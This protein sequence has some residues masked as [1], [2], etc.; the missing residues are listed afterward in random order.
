MCPSSSFRKASHLRLT[1]GR[2]LLP[3]KE[4][5]TFHLQQAC[6]PEKVDTPW[7]RRWRAMLLGKRWTWRHPVEPAGT[8]FV[9][10]SSTHSAAQCCAVQRRLCRMCRSP[11]SRMSARAGAR[12]SLP[13]GRPASGAA[14]ASAVESLSAAALTCRSACVAVRVRS[15]LSTRLAG[16]AIAALLRK[17][18]R[19]RE[20]LLEVYRFRLVSAAR[21]VALRP[22]Q[23]VAHDAS[24]AH[25]RTLA[26]GV[27]AP[28]G[29]GTPI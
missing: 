2:S 12:F 23:V 9:T 27:A 7:G 13:T 16:A 26:P 8:R 6:C 19:K 11:C 14:C 5:S 25:I 3:L 29:T 18:R 20:L 21:A 24:S 15:C 4:T 28:E 1:G 17:H 10:K 22:R